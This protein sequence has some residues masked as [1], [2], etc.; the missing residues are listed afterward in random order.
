VYHYLARIL[1]STTRIYTLEKVLCYRILCTNTTSPLLLLNLSSLTT[2][3]RWTRWLIIAR[4]GQILAQ[5]H[6]YSR[7]RALIRARKSS[8]GAWFP[9]ASTRDL[10]LRASQV[11]LRFVGLHRH[12]QSNMLNTEKVIA[13]RCSSRNGGIGSFVLIYQSVSMR[14]RSDPVYV[15]EDIL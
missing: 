10:Y 11:K 4:I 6:Q 8:K 12:V 1:H 2:P 3:H 14:K 9:T 15:W 5:I 7:I 13:V